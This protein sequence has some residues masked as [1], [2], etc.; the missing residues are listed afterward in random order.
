MTDSSP[1]L[2][3]ISTTTLSR[4]K[5]LPE[6]IY[7][8]PKPALQFDAEGVPSSGEFGDVYFSRDDGLAE[9]HYIFLHHNQLSERWST[10]DP[11]IHYEF[12]IGET[13]FGTG[14]NFL[15]ACQLWLNTAPP[16]CQLVFISA[17]L[18]PLSRDELQTTLAAWPDLQTIA[19]E[20]IDKY[21]PRLEGMHVVSLF[22]NRI[23]LQ[24][25]FGDAAEGFGKL[26]SPS[27]GLVDAWFLDGFSPAK[28]P[29]MWHDDLFSQIGRLSKPQATVTT[30]TVAGIVKDGLRKTGFIIEKVPGHGR[31]KQMLRGIFHGEKSLLDNPLPYWAKPLS[32]ADTKQH[33][34]IIGAGL[35]GC[36]S[37]MALA[38]RGYRVTVIDR[39]ADAAQAA[40]GNN[41]G[42]LY[43]TLSA[44]PNKINLFSLFSFLYAQRF[45]KT[46]LKDNKIVGDLCGH[47]E[48]I[49][50]D[51]DNEL[52]ELLKPLI[53]SHPD[54]CRW[55]D[56]DEAS[57]IAGIPINFSALYFPNTG[58]LSPPSICNALLS[59]ENISTIYQHNALSLRADNGLWQ[60]LDTHQQII[61]ESNIVIIANAADAAM[62]EQTQWL[63]IKS[64]RGQTTQ[65]HANANSAKL[66][67]VIC[68]D[69][70]FPPAINHQHCIGATFDLHDQS[71][72]ERDADNQYNL[73][74]LKNALPDLFTDDAEPIINGRVSFRATTPD[75]LPMCGPAPIVEDFQCDYKH[76]RYDARFDIEVL[77]S[78]W[79][80]LYINAGHGARGLSS[81]PLCAEWL[82]SVIDDSTRPLPAEMGL[83]IHP[84]RFVIKGMIRNKM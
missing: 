41:Q 72:I 36:S 28:N 73:N 27:K 52:A 67:T 20:L 60:V 71:A 6:D 64:I 68:H 65:L 12:V 35:A 11:Q 26:I 46:L 18:Y 55:V 4:A 8:L 62:F 43:N 37:A 79:P 66:K 78:Y 44:K 15:A 16:H 40:S 33:I 63:P 84:A 7:R 30:F 23:Q 75:Y 54:L 51:R 31:K 19:N 17:E 47:L 21:P 42:I 39:H 3:T 57:A 45:Y 2:S 49:R 22:E 76:L 14:L 82:A 83:S 80:G 13:G 56:A 61:T 32:Q 77:G 24:L 1:P 50:D 34:T 74:A 59:H 9:T 29:Q 58:W 48:L 25:L 38:K 5:K 69:G 10:L 81:T 53:A 70:Y